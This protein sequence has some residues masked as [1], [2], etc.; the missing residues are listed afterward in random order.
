MQSRAAQRSKLP[1]I[2]RSLWIL[3]LLLSAL[4]L[5]APFIP[6]LTV[7]SA[8]GAVFVL[9]TATALLTSLLVVPLPRSPW[10]A[11]AAQHTLVALLLCL[12]ISVLPP[13]IPGWL[14][15]TILALYVASTESR[16]W[17]VTLGIG[18]GLLLGGAQGARTAV[19]FLSPAIGVGGAAYAACVAFDRLKLKAL[20]LGQ[21]ITKMK[22][23]AEFLEA[24]FDPEQDFRGAPR[25]KEA[26]TLKKVS[27]EARTVRDLE[28]SAHLTRTLAPFLELARGMNN[29]HAA[30][31]F[32]IDQSR[33]G[34]FLRAYDGPPEIFDAAVLPLNDDPVRFV[35]DRGRAFYATEYRTLLWALPYYKTPVRIGTLLA[36]PVR[37][38][39]VISGVLVVDHEE[40]QALATAE[41]VLQRLSHLIAQ[42]VENERET[43]AHAE[44]EVEFEAAAYASQR[45]AEIIEVKDIH[46]FVTRA[47]K[48]MAPG[49]IDSGIVRWHPPVIEGLPGMSEQFAEWMGAGTTTADRTWMAWYFNSS[50]ERLSIDTP[51]DRGL[52]LFRPGGGLPGETLLV[53]PLRFRNRLQGA[54]VAVGERGAF[55]P[56]VDRVL[57]LVANQ[58]AAA[59][60]LIELLETNMRLALHDG[61]TGL[62][63]RRAF[64][65]ALERSVAQAT[66]AGQPL[67]LLMIDL[68]HFKRLNDTYGHAIGDA[69]LQAAA[70]EIRHQVRAGDLGARYGGEEFAVI[71]PDTDGPAAFRMAERLRKAL[72]ERVV[73]AGDE[74]LRMTASCGVSATDLGYGTPETLIHSADE[75]L[76]ASKETGRNRTSLAGTPRG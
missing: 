59:I 49:T 13:V 32:D 20:N 11:R 22:Q 3:S 15:L 18:S 75:A 46:A 35:M 5:A 1:A 26:P 57:T 37:V 65:E 72:A 29:A 17:V 21:K 34:A 16:T 42:V 66:R 40:S 23:G 52:P 8:L 73:K 33:D 70:A 4:F 44:R 6:R 64:D 39:G 31:F 9:I 51:R 50:A 19:D 12:G 63:N 47:I 28:R 36:V 38:R 48:E 56:H 41:P 74:Q 2:A 76:Y 68:D 25:V 69:A 27:A 14:L 30:L 10:T 60:D 53:H 55:S 7:G 58:A 61:L 54:L 62:L 24:E 45:L 43:Q 67:S 71:L